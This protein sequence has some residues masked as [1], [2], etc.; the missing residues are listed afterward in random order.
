MAPG[1]SPRSSSI[2]STPAASISAYSD[3][4][5][6]FDVFAAVHAHGADDHGERRN[7]VGPDDAALVM[8]LLD[9]CSGQAGDADAVAAHFQRL[10][11]AVFV[12]EGGVHGAAVLGAQIEHMA[13]FDAALNGQNPL[14]IGRGVTRHHIAHVGHGVWLRQVTAP[15]HAGD[16]ESPLRWR[17]RSSRPSPPLRGRHDLDRLLQADGPQVTGLAAKVVFNL[18]HGGEAEAASS[19]GTLPP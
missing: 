6:W 16:V 13:H 2:T 8:V 3:S 12:Q 19:P 18:G 4:A 14:A 10:R 1:R 17:R 11:F 5:A 15:V 7:G 9:G